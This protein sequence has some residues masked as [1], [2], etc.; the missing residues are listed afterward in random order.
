MNK[1][2]IAILAFAAALSVS[3]P[4][5]MASCPV[6]TM[7]ISKQGKELPVHAWK[8][9]RVAFIGDSITD[10]D[11]NASEFKYWDY[12]REWLG[13]EPFVYAVSG[14][15]WNDVPNQAGQLLE[16]RG[17]DFDAIIIL[18]GTND[19]NHGVP[20]GQWYTESAARVEASIGEPKALVHRMRRNTC[21]T[22]STFRGRINIAMRDLKRRFPTKQVLVLTPLRRSCF[23]AGDRNW[24]PSEDYTN[25]AGEYLDAYVEA[26]KEVA[27][28]WA[29]P[30]I[31]LGALSGLFPMEDSNTVYFADPEHDRLHPND[32]GHK[33]LALTLYY[34]L[35]ALPCSFE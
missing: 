25:W 27:E 15:E 4:C 20:L 6:K 11:N 2:I 1:S 10:P 17:Q 3:K 28:V 13:I 16:E 9:R 12:L 34:Q 29:V 7:G 22:D 30:V 8:G 21:Y 32:A 35:Q 5:S 24:Q 14:R 26:V 33:R 31:D 18:M 19:Y 23:H